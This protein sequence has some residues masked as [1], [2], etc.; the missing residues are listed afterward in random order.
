MIG[1]RDRRGELFPLNSL[2]P[3]RRAANEARIRADCASTYLGDGLAL[4]RV[5]GRFKMY[6]DT[7]DI[8]L[9][10]HLIL[11]GFWDIWLTEAIAAAVKPGSVFVDIGA[12][13]GYFS[14]LAAELCGPTGRVHAFEPN[15]A[16]ADLLT[17]S[18]AV[19]G[20]TQRIVLHRTALADVDG[21]RFRLVVPPGEPKNA[22]IVPADD[23]AEGAGVLISRRLDSFEALHRADVIKID[24]EGAE[25]MIWAGMAGL[26]AQ[27]RPCTIFLEFN[28]ARYADPNAFLA[29]LRA[30]GFTVA[31]LMG[32]GDE[33]VSDGDILAIER[34]DQMLV[35]RR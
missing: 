33:P 26:F 3:D 27:S 19:N 34:D 29:A 4:C 12:N 32:Q 14:L 10:P 17:N 8:G 7:R 20:F 16:I 23:A 6:V 22:H 30:P 35:L 28:T 25:E 21:R 2:T 13:L 15:P 11:D 24:A 9:S 31:R 18:R 1:R 5:L